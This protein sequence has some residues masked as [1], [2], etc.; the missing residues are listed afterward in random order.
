[1]LQLQTRVEA[2]RKPVIAHAYSSQGVL[3]TKKE[4]P[5]ARLCQRCTDI[6]VDELLSC[7]RQHVGSVSPEGKIYIRLGHIHSRFFTTWCDL[8]RFFKRA[9][10]SDSLDTPLVFKDVDKAS[11]HRFPETVHTRPFLPGL[12]VV[13]TK[14]K[15]TSG[16]PCYHGGHPFCAV[17][18][19]NSGGRLIEPDGVDYSLL[20]GWINDCKVS[21]VECSG[22][23]FLPRNVIDCKQRT[24]KSLKDHVPYVALSYV[25]GNSYVSIE[26]PTATCSLPATIPATIEDAITVTLGLQYEYLWVDKYCIKQHGGN[27]KAQEIARM[28]EIYRGAEVVLID[29]AG[30][31]PT[32]GLPGVSR[33]RNTQPHITLKSRTLTSLLSYP[34]DVIHRSEWAKRGWT[35]QEGAL[36]QRRLFFTDDQVYFECHIHG[37]METLCQTVIHSAAYG[38]VSAPSMFVTSSYD[39]SCASGTMLVKFYLN[40]YSKRSLRYSSDIL[41]AFRGIFHAL[42]NREVPILHCGGVPILTNDLDSQVSISAANW[43]GFLR[44][45][46][47]YSP[48]NIAIRRPDFPSWSW[49]GWEYR[50]C[51]TGVKL[52]ELSFPVHCLL[53]RAY[54]SCSDR[55]MHDPLGFD[56]EADGEQGAFEGIPCQ[57]SPSPCAIYMTGKVVTFKYKVTGKN[58]AYCAGSANGDFWFEHKNRA[59]PARRGCRKPW[60]TQCW[61][62]GP[63]KSDYLQSYGPEIPEGLALS[64]V[65]IL[66]HG[67]DPNSRRLPSRLLGGSIR[68]HQG[69]QTMGARVKLILQLLRPLSQDVNGREPS[70]SS[71]VRKYKAYERVGVLQVEFWEFLDYEASDWFLEAT[72]QDIVIV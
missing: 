7:K 25:W 21:H 34:V 30:A 16:E 57:V 1:M 20:R 39:N 40:Q 5:A 12:L 10:P 36:A 13:A 24:I 32:L 58:H 62:V 64:A 27:E 42:G 68:G 49:T 37:C 6:N 29:A 26:E 53:R 17:D 52:L 66:G 70:S 23:Q 28:D 38:P 51:P 41:N 63:Y 22:Q 4:T 55:T 2:S 19:R 67:L 54:V 50:E 71:P 14:D 60:F 61:I 48:R 46:C 3:T 47:W 11:Y 45:L 35:Y 72:E 59:F 15:Y 69:N 43:V 9:S 33:P 8:C 56:S 44:G 31:D 18:S 65:V